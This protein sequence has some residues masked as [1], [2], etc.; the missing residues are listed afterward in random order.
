M[1]IYFKTFFV[2]ACVV[3]LTHYL[4]TCP[5]A[6]QFVIP[7]NGLEV[8][9]G[10]FGVLYAIIIGFAIFEVL[11]NYNEIKALMNAEVNELQDLRDY[12]MYVDGQDETKKEIV[13]HIKRY[14]ESVV[15]EEWPAMCS[16]KKLDI[17]TPDQMY[18]VMKSVNKIKPAN[19]S[20]VMALQKLIDTIGTVTTHRTDRITASIERLPSLLTQLIFILSLFM[21][22]IFAMIPIDSMV[23]KMTLIGI[24]TF[25]IAFIYFVIRDLDYPFGGIWSIQ[26]EPFKDFIARFDK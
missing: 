6:K 10:L 3:G 19:D 18:D 22:S 26:P 4:S 1:R 2:V 9:F 7:G 23:I 14:A 13:S 11:R 24:N 20:D 21:V 12:L 16:Y 17:D 8:F 15:N 25:G 5:C